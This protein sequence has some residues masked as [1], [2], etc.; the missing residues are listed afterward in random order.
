M[1]DITLLNNET[2]SANYIIKMKAIALNVECGVD[3]NPES[4]KHVYTN[5]AGSQASQKVC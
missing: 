2:G 3:F 4:K 5:S 1:N